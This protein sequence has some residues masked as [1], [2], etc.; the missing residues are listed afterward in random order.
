M[1]AG[2]LRDRRAQLLLLLAPGVGYLLVFFGG[3]LLS[4]LIGSFRQEDGSF[5]LMFYERI[6]TRASMI[7]GLTTSI[8]YGVMPVIVS[9]AASVPLALLIRKAFLGENC[10]AAFTSCRWRC[11]ASSSA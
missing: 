1:M 7:R 10:S 11:R 9:L 3:P 2:V 5:T 6:F 8:Y 4:A